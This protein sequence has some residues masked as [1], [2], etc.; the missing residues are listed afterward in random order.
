M[1]TTANHE[2][3]AEVNL[4]SLEVGAA[5]VVAAF[6][7]RLGLEAIFARHRA[8]AG[9]GRPAALAPARVLT[10]LVTNVLVA[11]LPLYAVPQWLARFVPETISLEA[12]QRELFN[13]D[14]LGRTLAASN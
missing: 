6:L 11:R 12:P 13:D 2:R 14:R 5:P 3:L 10:T 8:P 1:Q 7:Q 4:E 9:R